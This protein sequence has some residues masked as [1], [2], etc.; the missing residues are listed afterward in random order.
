MIKILLLSLTLVLAASAAGD[1]KKPVGPP[2]GA[3]QISETQW[4][5]TGPDGKAWI[6]TR[7]PFGW[8]R[9]PEDKVNPD[10][11]AMPSKPG[12]A[13]EVVEI[14]E[15]EAVFQRAT[16]FGRSRWTKPLADLDE[17]ERAAVAA[18]RPSKSN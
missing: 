16:P 13:L 18:A 9:G 14:R 10:T 5:H 7:T 6:Y 2:A 8:S 15:S 17:A 12:P 1:A 11:K 4:R 3:Q